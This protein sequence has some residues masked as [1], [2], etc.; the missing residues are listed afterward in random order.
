MRRK[1]TQHTN[2]I[3]HQCEINADPPTLHAFRIYFAFI[4]ICVLFWAQGPSPGPKMAAS[5]GLGL[6][7]P[8]PSLGLG[9]ALGPQIQN[10]YEINATEMRKSCNVGGSTFTL[11]VCCNYVVVYLYWLCI[12]CI[13]V[14]SNACKLQWFSHVPNLHDMQQCGAVPEP[15]IIGYG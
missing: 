4:S 7:S 3:Q 12:V 14:F 11:H 2:T 8:P 15:A 9:L 1:Y 10:I 5:L 6:G 13:C